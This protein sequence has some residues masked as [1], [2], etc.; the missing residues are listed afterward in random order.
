MLVFRNAFNNK[1]VAIAVRPQKISDKRFAEIEEACRQG[2]AYTVAA[3]LLTIMR[4]QR[5]PDCFL[6]PSG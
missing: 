3:D 2:R 6:L 5:H 4:E 1:I